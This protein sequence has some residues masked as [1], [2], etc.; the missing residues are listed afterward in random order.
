MPKITKLPKS[1]ETK[2]VALTKP[3]KEVGAEAAPVLY[4]NHVAITGSS[5]DVRLRMSQIEKVEDGQVTA[6]VMATVYLSPQHAKAVADLLNR[7][8][9]EFDRLFPTWQNTS[10]ADGKA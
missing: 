2:I 1:P 10:G 4:T 9:A 7:K 3:P 5:W 8:L 6:R